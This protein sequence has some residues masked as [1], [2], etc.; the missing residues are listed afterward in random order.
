MVRKLKLKFSSIDNKFAKSYSSLAFVIL[1]LFIFNSL[2]SHGQENSKFTLKFK[3]GE[4]IPANNIDLFVDGKMQLPPFVFGSSFVVLQFNTLPSFDLKQTLAEKGV[5]LLDYLTANAYAA[6]ISSHE[7]LSL[8]K[9]A[10]VRSIFVLEPRFKMDQG[11]LQDD[12][13][14]WATKEPGTVDVNLI[15]FDWISPDL[16]KEE[17]Q[18]INARLIT[19][20]KQFRSL[21]IRIP[22]DQLSNLVL[23]PWLQ[24]M[25]TI[26]PAPQDDNLPGKTLH[27]SNVLNDGFRNLTG[28]SVHIGI[29]DGGTV[30]PHID[31]AGRLVLAEPY[32]STDHGTHVAGTMAGAGLLDP[33]ARGM[34]PKARVYSYYYNGDVNS[35]VASAISTYGITMT[36]NSWGYGDGF[37]NCT[38][39]DPYNS[40]S[41][42]QDINI[43]NNPTLVHV[44]S[45]GNSQGVCAG[46]WGTTTGKAAK[47][48]L[49]VANVTSSDVL[50]SSSSCGPVADGR[51]KPEISGM[52]TSVYSTTPNNTYTGGYSGTSMAT[53]GV[54]GTIAQLVQRYRQL[55]GNTTPPA[56]LMKVL[57]CNTA[58]DLGNPGPDYKYG[59]GRINGLQAVRAMENNRYRIDSLSTGATNSFSI[60]V[61]ANSK[62]LK[63]MICWT[64][65]AGAV[66]ANPALVNDLDLTVIDPSVNTWNPWVLDS[67][68]PA[69]NATRMADHLNNIEQVTL[70]NPSGGTYSFN[71]SGFSVPVGS[72]Q[73]YSITWEIESAY[74]EISYPNGKEVFVPTSTEVIYWD[75][76]GLTANQTL[77][78]SLNNGASWT[79][80]S[81]S[82]SSTTYRYSWSVPSVVTGQARIRITSG[83]LSDMSDS[84]FSILGSP[85]NLVLSSGCISGQISLS[86][87][88]VTNASHYDVMQLDPVAGVWNLVGSAI[89]GTQHFVSG[90]TPGG[91]YWFTVRARSNTNSVVGKNA[92]AKSILVPTVLASPPSVLA[93]G[94]LE[95]CAGDTLI[96]SAG[97]VIP[98]TYLVNSIPFQSYTPGADIPVTLTDD[99]V[100]AALP[101][102]FTFNFFG[103]PYS[104][105]YIG[106]NGIIGFNSTSLGGTYT[107][108]LIPDATSPN[109]LIAF[110]WTDLNPSSGGT[111]TYL[112]TG[113]I[114]NRKLIVSYNNVNRYGSSAVVNGRIELSEGSDIIEIYTTEV[115]SGTNTM[116]IEDANGSSG[117]SVAGRNKSLWSVTI[118]EG[119]Q[120][121]P[122]NSTIVWE[123]GSVNAST[124]SVTNPNDYS[125]SY[126]LNGCPLYSDTATVTSSCVGDVTVNIKAFL[127]GFYRGGGRLVNNL[128]A[129]TCDTLIL[130]LAS[131][132]EPFNILFSDTAILDTN[133][134]ASF[135]FP[136]SVFS[137][138]YYLVLSHRNSM[139]T[140]S[141]AS[142]LMNST[143]ISY[144]FTSSAGSAYGNNLCNMGDGSFAIW[145]GD[146][147]RNLI[148]DFSDLTL[149]QNYIQQY[150]F[151]YHV[152]DLNGDNHV[153][154]ADYSLIEN[155]LNYSIQVLKP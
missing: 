20:K 32:L 4:F 75:H 87:S 71:V 148:I 31:F 137:N 144:D 112:T 62:R 13:P 36:Q 69:N 110:A 113:T 153:E 82:I 65:P 119:I 146:I 90:L 6:R 51:L 142:L 140:W 152:A 37:V 149:L 92:I 66:N 44:H 88:A 8:L 105:F 73:I 130:K 139:E 114:P 120:F 115:S 103:T 46:G 77:Q 85:L 38:T 98:N 143:G 60:S 45:S 122:H 86:W 74:I 121:V 9:S 53:P 102:G 16:L 79:T 145:G 39:K 63:V 67:A 1:G 55:N 34:A 15:M 80:I 94:P 23:R 93:D 72:K 42:E 135:V 124:L 41:R 11:L 56:S 125:F 78:Y 100:T 116:G 155:N 49:V 138:S 7:Q 3:S 68:L 14:V 27:R 29:W 40:N 35:E 117:V 47:N 154:S 136:G 18:K 127:Q 22:V 89:S 108:Q 70:D 132:I 107:P 150:L 12:I 134:N 133:G 26:S 50:S 64:D 25:E 2:N 99:D 129:G 123:P 61:P 84:V 109:S 5:F 43:A 147:D 52:G 151:N 131:N 21:T 111:I 106:S 141:A 97:N 33:F 28:D 24:W 81:S 30:G 57:A 76:L 104:Q 128:S 83:A 95:A 101:V 58:K 17:F 96:L 48:M 59:F 126:S 10:G 19:S 91:T 118:P 54:S